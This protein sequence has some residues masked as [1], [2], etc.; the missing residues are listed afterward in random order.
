MFL[1]A[2]AEDLSRPRNMVIAPSISPLEYELV[3]VGL[4]IADVVGVLICEYICSI[5][6][7]SRWAL[8]PKS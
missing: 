6:F 7:V 4:I 5:F 3:W 8:L 2:V 1:N